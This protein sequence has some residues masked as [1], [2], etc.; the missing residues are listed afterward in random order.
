MTSVMLSHIIMCS[1]VVLIFIF[2][3][4]F[5][6]RGIDDY[7]GDERAFPSLRVKIIFTVGIVYWLVS[8][9]YVL[10]YLIPSR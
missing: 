10:L 3:L 6:V 1:Y 4:L 7:K 2:L 8:G 5:F 9:I